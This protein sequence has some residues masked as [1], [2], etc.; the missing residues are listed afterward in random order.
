[1]SEKRQ[2]EEHYLEWKVKVFGLLKEHMQY[3][4]HD[5]VYEPSI[6]VEQDSSLEPI[7]LHQ[8]D[9]YVQDRSRKA[10]RLVSPVHTLPV[11]ATRELLGIVKDRN[12]VHMEVDLQEYPGLKYKTGDHLGALLS[13]YLEICSAVSTETIAALIQFAPN[14]SAKTHLTRLSSDK[15]AYDE[16]SSAA[17]LNFGRLLRHA[18]PEEGAWNGLPLAFIVEALP[19]MQPRY[20][21]ISS[22]SVT[23]ARQIAITAIVSDKRVAGDA[24]VPGLCTN[25]LLG[26]QRA[27][28]AESSHETRINAHV[29]KST[30]KLPAVQPHPTIMVAAGTGI[31]PFRAFIQERARLSKMGRPIGRTIL[32][33]GCRNEYEDYLYK[34]ELREW[35]KI[36]ELQLSVITAFSRPSAGDK[37]YVQQR[38]QEKADEV[39]DLVYEKEELLHLRIGCHGKRC[40][41]G[42]R[43][44]VA[45]PTR[46]E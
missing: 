10:D 44:R 28:L 15:A 41:E 39:C 31:A 17:Y 24:V 12:C 45:S 30:F 16:L 20:Y 22:S 27:H 2:T 26:A 4:E 33:F 5:P 8:G 46:L 43:A 3:E 9:P 11:K 38:V 6:P 23:H 36:P 32:L 42:A 19:A 18:A 35:E 13:S 37:I 29:R 40:L 25:H 21:S 14:E 1:M 7:D 34:D